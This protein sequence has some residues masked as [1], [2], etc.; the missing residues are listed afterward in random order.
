[1]S[2]L[3]RFRGTSWSYSRRCGIFTRY[4]NF[5]KS[6]KYMTHI[7]ENHYFDVE[8][9]LHLKIVQ[10]TQFHQNSWNWNQVC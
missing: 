7:C 4:D 2:E 10:N 1:M 3:F 5:N 6:L 8:R 9:W